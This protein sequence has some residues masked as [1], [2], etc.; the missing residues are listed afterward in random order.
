MRSLFVYLTSTPTSGARDAGGGAT[1]RRKLPWR[2]TGRMPVLEAGQSGLLKPK[3]QRPKSGGG[4]WKGARGSGGKTRGHATNCVAV[5]AGVVGALAR[6]ASQNAGRSQRWSIVIIAIST[7]VL[8]SIRS[9]GSPRAVRAN[10]PTLG[11]PSI[12]VSSRRPDLRFSCVAARA[13]KGARWAGRF[14]VQAR[15]RPITGA[16]FVR[17]GI[18]LALLG[19]QLPF[20]I[21]P[22]TADCQ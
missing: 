9:T 18:T 4:A 3:L 16:D 21:Q 11:I 17:G 8:A 10:L 22:L 1:R 7:G 5:C 6:N 14:L 15:H 20:Q 12:R 19:K 2:E 13:Q